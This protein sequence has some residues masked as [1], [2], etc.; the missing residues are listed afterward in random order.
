MRCARRKN[1]L[2]QVYVPYPIVCP[3]VSSL[4]LM[5]ASWVQGELHR[6]RVQHDELGE[7]HDV[8][9][10]R[11]H[12]LQ[13]QCDDLKAKLAS[14]QRENHGVADRLT[15]AS[16]MS[17]RQQELIAQLRAESDAKQ[18]AMDGMQREL[19]TAS[20]ANKGL[21]GER[22]EG[23]HMHQELAE[24][25]DDLVQKLQDAEIDIIKLEEEVGMGATLPFCPDACTCCYHRYVL[26][27]MYIPL[28][29]VCAVVL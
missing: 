13:E 11:Q 22:L 15:A 14:A 18:R 12:I 4:S 1:V 10:G 26:F 8:E 6:L 7:S 3:C 16:T 19:A 17:Q 28:T 29:V 9:Q 21:E 2:H 25:I 23:A 24:E 5:E 27:G 20:A